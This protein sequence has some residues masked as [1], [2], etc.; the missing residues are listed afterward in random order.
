M[1]RRNFLQSVLAFLG[2]AGAGIAKTA[3]PVAP[4]A[5]RFSPG[6]TTALT[7]CGWLPDGLIRQ[8]VLSL[9]VPLVDS[10]RV[11]VAGCE[12][13][14]LGQHAAITLEQPIVDVAEGGAWRWH[15]TAGR[16][17]ASV[18]FGRLVGRSQDMRA[19]GDVCGARSLT[20]SLLAAQGDDAPALFD[21]RHAVLLS[22][23]VWATSGEMAVCEQ[24]T[25]ICCWDRLMPE[26]QK[27]WDDAI[28]TAFETT[29]A[30]C[31]LPPTKP[32]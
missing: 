23:A 6:L 9:R 31:Q 3:E 8:R 30:G 5:P 24:A 22:T 4:V 10:A 1:I 19:L 7:H 18:V 16:R 13:P 32:S 27:L 26:L 14:F 29:E 2:F 17:S 21:A 11:E 15:F 12:A 28:A 20:L 25:I